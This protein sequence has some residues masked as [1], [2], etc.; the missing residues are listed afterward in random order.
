MIREAA[1][2]SSSA[3]GRTASH[4][5]RSLGRGS[6]L[7]VVVMRRI[8]RLQSGSDAVCLVVHVGTRGSHDQVAVSNEAT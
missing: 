8:Q 7:V 4:A 6:F 1:V 3:A 5:I 2:Q